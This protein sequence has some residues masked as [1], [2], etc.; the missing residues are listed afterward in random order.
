MLLVSAMCWTWEGR[1]WAWQLNTGP[2]CRDGLSP[3]WLAGRSQVVVGAKP[4]EQPA[5]CTSVQLA[6]QH[7]VL[8][9]CLQACMLCTPQP[10]L[11]A[12]VDASM[13]RSI[14]CASNGAL[15]QSCRAAGQSLPQPCFIPRI[16]MSC[17]IVCCSTVHTLLRLMHYLNTVPAECCT[18]SRCHQHPCNCA[19]A[20]LPDALWHRNLQACLSPCVT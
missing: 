18:A 13:C 5:R 15:Q 11:C 9:C 19:A 8:A 3:T 2:I 10:A 20:L 1:H 6:V 12:R 17:Q 16:Q 14:G 7:V 4:S